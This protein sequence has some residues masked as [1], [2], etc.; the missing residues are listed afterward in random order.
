MSPFSLPAKLPL[1]VSPFVSWFFFFCFF[2]EILQAGQSYIDHASRGHC[3]LVTWQWCKM[4]L[5]SI[6]Q[7]AWCC[8]IRNSQYFCSRWSHFI[9][10]LMSHLEQRP[11]P[12]VL[13]STDVFSQSDNRPFSSLSASRFSFQTAASSRHG[14]YFSFQSLLTFPPSARQEVK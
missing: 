8:K 4:Y 13:S 5:A 10:C 9:R 6:E 11:T 1:S 2:G 7:P 3:V 14:V 12:A